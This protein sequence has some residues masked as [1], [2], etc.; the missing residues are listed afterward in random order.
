MFK[1]SISK[2]KC[3]Y[4]AKL[5]GLEEGK[6]TYWNVLKIFSLSF[7]VVGVAIDF[8]MLA[9]LAIAVVLGKMLA[10]YSVSAHLFLN[11]LKGIALGGA[12]IT[13]AVPPTVIIAS[14]FISGLY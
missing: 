9:L 10:A 1:G 13:F 11:A 6:V 8:A 3:Y 7:A 4:F 2:L 5:D 14:V 12:L